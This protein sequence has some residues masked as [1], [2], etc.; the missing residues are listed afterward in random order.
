VSKDKNYILSAWVKVKSGT[1]I[2]AAEFREAKNTVPE[3]KW[4]LLES[5]LKTVADPFA[6][7]DMLIVPAQATPVWEYKELKINT[8]T[9]LSANRGYIRV[10]I[11]CPTGEIYIDDM[12]LYPEKSLVSTDYYS[13]DYGL[14]IAM[15]DANN[16]AKY[17]EYD[18][19]GRLSHIYNNSKVLIK[20]ATSTM[21]GV[22]R[23]LKLTV[24]VFGQIG[25]AN[26]KL[27][28]SWTTIG[29][30]NNVRLSYSGDKA[31]WTTI[32][33]LV[34]N[35]GT[36]AWPV[37]SNLAFEKDYWIKIEDVSSPDIVYNISDSPFRYKKNWSFIK[38]W[39][40]KLLDY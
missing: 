5:E 9:K 12:R 34:A 10:E 13:L 20:E 19:F 22:T 30:V 38:R 7:S 33:A 8:M 26:V 27:P 39:V 36:Y 4:P 25:M 1:A 3:N 29:T 31:T 32:V 16:K 2:F 21:S 24:P 23:Q 18:G 37:P 14:P 40:L 28:L 35:T 15:V 17:F 11:G 6:I